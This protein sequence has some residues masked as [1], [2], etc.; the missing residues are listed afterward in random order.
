MRLLYTLPNWNVYDFFHFSEK[1][2]F[3]FT[4]TLYKV[5][6]ESMVYYSVCIQNVLNF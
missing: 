4:I 3:E 2:E 5:L 1:K 6:Y